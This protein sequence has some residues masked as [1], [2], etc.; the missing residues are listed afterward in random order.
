MNFL[1]EILAAMIP[2]VISQLPYHFTVGKVTVTIS[3]TPIVP[4]LPPA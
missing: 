4:P 1:K 3:L 2:F